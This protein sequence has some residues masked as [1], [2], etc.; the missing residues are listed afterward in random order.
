MCDCQAAAPRDGAD[1]DERERYWVGLAHSH[2]KVIN[3]V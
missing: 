2:V 3:D 1:D